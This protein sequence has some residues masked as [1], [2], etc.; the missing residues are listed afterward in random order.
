MDRSDQSGVTT[1]APVID[2]GG[3][4]S[5]LVDHLLAGGFR[6]SLAATR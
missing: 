6:D 2:V 5:T 1:D 4:E 3:G